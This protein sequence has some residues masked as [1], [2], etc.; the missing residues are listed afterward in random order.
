MKPM[1][2]MLLRNF[3]SKRRLRNAL[4][5]PL[6]PKELKDVIGL[7]ARH[8]D[9]NTVGCVWEDLIATKLLQDGHMLNNVIVWQM[10]SQKVELT[11][12]TMKVQI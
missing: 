10:L 3:G 7:F 12:C 4:N 5:A 2:K 8:V 11:K 6:Q 1:R 9:M